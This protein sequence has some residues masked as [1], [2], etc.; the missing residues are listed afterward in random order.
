MIYM[1]MGKGNAPDEA[2]REVE[3]CLLSDVNSSF[4]SAWSCV[5]VCVSVLMWDC[6]YG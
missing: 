2:K 1:M 4:A 5:C 6:L 3:W